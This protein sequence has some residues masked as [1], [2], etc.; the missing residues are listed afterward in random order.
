MHKTRLFTVAFLG[1]VCVAMGPVVLQA[2]GT[3]A[4]SGAPGV[5]RAEMEEF[6]STAD[7]KETET[8]SRGV[9]GAMLATLS[10]GDQIHQA[11]IQTVD[12]FKPTMKIGG[13]TIR[14]FRDSYKYNIAAYKLDKMLGTNLVPTT[15]ERAYKGKKAAF[16]IWVDPVMMTEATRMANNAMPPDAASWNHQINRVRVFTQLIYDTD[17]NLGNL[18]ITPQWRIWKVDLTRS[19]RQFKQLEDESKLLTID[20]DFYDALKTLTLDSCKE[21]L[22]DQLS[23]PEIKALLERRDRIIEMFDEKAAAEGRD[24]VITVTPS[25]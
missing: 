10:K 25:N 20:Q 8:L 6:L 16:T 12:I 9:T 11:Q 3:D 18:L 23:G 4:E 21:T 5:P 19:F 7:V 22:G 2:Q 1:V 14:N 13:Q 24:A 15:V 17:P